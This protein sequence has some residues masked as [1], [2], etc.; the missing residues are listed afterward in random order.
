MLSVVCI[1]YQLPTDTLGIV[2]H[3]HGG[4]KNKIGNS[5]ILPT[6]INHDNIQHCLLA[7]SRLIGYSLTGNTMTFSTI[8]NTSTA[9]RIR[10]NKRCLHKTTEAT[11]WIARLRD[12][13]WWI[14]VLLCWKKSGAQSFQQHDNEKSWFLAQQT[15][16]IASR[17]WQ[18][19]RDDFWAKALRMNSFC[20]KKLSGGSLT[21]FYKIKGILVAE[22]KS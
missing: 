20:G 22:P 18:C 9:K 6:F 10:E 7:H 1:H 5:G 17:K 13:N 8:K 16:S 19:A 15:T 4:R 14:N 3:C 12:R 21:W 2:R 11:A